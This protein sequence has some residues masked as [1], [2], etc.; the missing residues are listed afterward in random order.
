[1]AVGV[2][3]WAGQHRRRSGAV[4]RFGAAGVPAVRDPFGRQLRRHLTSNGVGLELAV[5][6]PQPTTLAGPAS[7]A[8]AGP[9]ST[10]TPRDGGLAMDPGGAAVQ[11]ARWGRRI[12]VGSLATVVPPGAEVLREW[13]R[14]QG[15]R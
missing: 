2:W 15:C 13:V 5:D 12:H 8:G 9:G 10:S 1:V 3:G 6:A 14:G 7:T 11:A 4:G